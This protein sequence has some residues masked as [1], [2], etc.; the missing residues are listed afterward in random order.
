MTKRILKLTGIT[1]LSVLLF[2]T[3]VFGTLKTILDQKEIK[4]IVREKIQTFLRLDVDYDQVSTVIFPRPGIK[5]SGL[6]IHDGDIEI[7][8]IE[9][10]KI[11][12]DLLALLDGE[13]TIRSASLKNGSLVIERE[14]DGQISL[15]SKF[16][17]DAK[18]L[19]EG[20]QK[21]NEGPKAL[22]QFLPKIVTLKN[23]NVEYIDNYLK[24]KNNLDIELLE[25]SF[26]KKDLATVIEL[27]ASI[28]KNQFILESNTSLTQNQ[29]SMESLRTKTQLSLLHFEP[30]KMGDLFDIFVKGDTRESFLDLDLRLEKE[31]DDK[32]HIALENLAWNGIK[33]KKGIPIPMLKIQSE[34]DLPLKDSKIEL[35][36]F[37]FAF[38][39]HTELNLHGWASYMDPQVVS[40]GIQSP[41]F[42]FDKLQPVIEMISN[43]DT[44]KS[45]YFPSQESKNREAETKKKVHPQADVSLNMTKFKIGGQYIAS[46]QGLITLRE[47]QIAFKNVSTSIYDGKVVSSGGL[48]LTSGQLHV[49]AILSKINV[50][51]AIRSGTNDKLLTG[52]LRSDLTLDLN[53]KSKQSLMNQ[54][55]LKSKFH[56]DK[57]QLLGYANFIRPVAAIG[58]LLN[59][60]GAKGESTAFETIDG[61]IALSN[62]SIFLKQFQMQ[63]VGLNATGAGI[64]SENGK[65]D[66]KFT[67]GLSGMVGKAVKL[68]IIYKGFYGQNFAYI[69]P[70]WLAYV[71]AGTLMGGPAGTVLGSVV[72]TKA[73][74]N[75]DKSIDYAKEKIDD[76][77]G[78]FFGKKKTEEKQPD[79]KK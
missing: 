34:L 15:V 60:D 68:P 72:G 71:Y 28:N 20:R 69:D 64:Y 61:E 39:D 62:G 3:I 22:F 76:I 56:I 4:S 79:S 59:F 44:Q 67:V 47:N 32:L 25:I 73:S 13:F 41:R 23:L 63:G 11:A 57:G 35:N 29:W 36:K 46:L 7:C 10:V 37:T 16:K 27:N 38:G 33:T 49:A 12:F 74:D 40:M 66:M 55:R 42:D 58:K 5:I 31:S 1:F 21:I 75:V 30:S 48:N 77:S 14:M 17:S 70:V 26:N 6:L 2:L 51:K 45:S 78:F 53:I 8:K 18:E 52:T 19:D 65:I 50:E 43:V 54:L 9:Q 24:T